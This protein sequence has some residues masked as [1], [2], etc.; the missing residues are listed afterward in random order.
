VWNVFANPD[1]PNPKRRSEPFCVM[2]TFPWLVLP[3]VFY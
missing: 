3:T 1:M 2:N